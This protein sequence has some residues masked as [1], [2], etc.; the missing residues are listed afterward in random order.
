MNVE[1]EGN[2]E[3][4]EDEGGDR[5]EPGKKSGDAV[6]GRQSEVPLRN[7][8]KDNGLTSCDPCS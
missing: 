2:A 3:R 5:T 6:P 7:K 4:H 1:V 8:G